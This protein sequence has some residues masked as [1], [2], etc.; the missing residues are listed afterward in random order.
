MACSNINRLPQ[1]QLLTPYRNAQQPNDAERAQREVVARTKIIEATQGQVNSIKIQIKAG[2]KIIEVTEEQQKLLKADISDLESLLKIQAKAIKNG[3]ETLVYVGERIKIIEARE[4][5]LKSNS[6]EDHT[7]SPI[8]D[9]NEP[10]Y[11]AYKKQLK[12]TETWV[13]SLGKQ[14]LAE[15]AT[16]NTTEKRQVFAIFNDWWN[17]RNTSI[18]SNI[19]TPFSK[20]F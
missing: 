3:E 18:L 9:E 15:E 13:R 11:K 10:S 20:W 19:Y 7:K 6:T 16:I 17:G 1:I 2:E 5:Q 8:L 12:D 4:A 14:R